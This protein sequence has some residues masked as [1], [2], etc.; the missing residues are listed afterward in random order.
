MSFATDSDYQEQ[1]F[2]RLIWKYIDG[3]KDKKL[4]W[5]FAGEA[6]GDL[7]GAML[8]R[9]LKKVLNDRVHIAGM[10]SHQMRDAGVE[11]MVDSSELGIVGIVEVLKHIFLFIKIF[12]QLRKRALKERPDAV[13]LI[14]YPGFNLRFAKQMFKNKIPVIWYISPQVWVW[15]KNRIPKL[16]KYCRKMLVIF[17]FETE[18]YKNTGLDIEFVGHP[19]IEIIGGQ[20]NASIKRDPERLL[21]LPGSRKDEV[22]RLLPDMLET[23]K[24]LHKK[25]PNLKYAISAPRETIHE[26]VREIYENYRKKPGNETLPA[27]E[28][29][30]GET[31]RWM[32]EAG[33]GLAAS[34]TVT[35]ECAISGLPLV[36]IYRVNA[37]TF[38]F[39]RLVI[40]KFFRNFFCMVN[41]IANREI[42]KEYIQDAVKP[43]ILCAE[44]E[45]ILPGGERREEVEKEIEKVVEMLSASGENTSSK[46]AAAILKA[47]A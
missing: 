31:V 15:G 16:A 2:H 25:K 1:P 44:L 35:V 41:I 7:Y 23:V 30:C 42:F 28:F 46:S 43:E 34:G 17:P 33:T 40:R 38:L 37:L 26:L 47:I 20:R 13:V 22:K 4:I 36:V 39:G 3:M 45:K 27:I 32:W 5:I 10:G 21:L 9:E 12:L 24:L 6:S 8:A 29:T 11:I 14:D 19:L 18:V